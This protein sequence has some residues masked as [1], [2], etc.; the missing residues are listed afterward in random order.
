MMIKQQ[1]QMLMLM[2]MLMLIGMDYLEYHQL[3][4]AKIQVQSMMN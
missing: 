1:I 3:Q 2:S 4:Q